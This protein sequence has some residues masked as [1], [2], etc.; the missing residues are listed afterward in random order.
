[1]RPYA[2]LIRHGRQ[3]GQAPTTLRLFHTCK[4]SLKA[5]VSAS[6]IGAASLSPRWLSDLKAKAQANVKQGQLLHESKR[7]LD[8]LDERWVQLLAGSEGFLSG[9]QW[10]GLSKETV[11]WGDM[12]SDAADALVIS[13]RKVLTVF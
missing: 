6:E 8:Q 13:L 9:P 10:A 1:M 12:V 5:D 2:G 3:I 7:V 11:R 4:A